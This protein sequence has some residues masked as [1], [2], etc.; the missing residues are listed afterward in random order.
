MNHYYYDEFL[1]MMD[2]YNA[3]HRTDDSEDG[4]YINAEEF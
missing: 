1:V 4:E 3:M 2:A